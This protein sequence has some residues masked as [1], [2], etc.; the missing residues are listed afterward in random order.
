MDASK[1]L[2][3]IFSDPAR[4]CETFLKNPM[5]SEKSLSLRSY[6]RV[7]LDNTR[8]YRNV[9]LRYGRRMGKSVTMCADTL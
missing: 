4:W 6:Q 1:E 2:R 3:D 9:I 8:K 5:D 7:V